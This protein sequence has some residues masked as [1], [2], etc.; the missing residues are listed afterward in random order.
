VVAALRELAPDGVLSPGRARSTG[1][2]RKAAKRLF[3]SLNAAAEAAGL[4]YQP[5]RPDGGGTGHWKEEVALKTLQRKAS[6]R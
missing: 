3:G 5:S 4:R 2:I 1:G 6:D